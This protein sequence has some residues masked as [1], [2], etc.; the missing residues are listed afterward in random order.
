MRTH[1]TKK[2]QTTFW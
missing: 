1:F 2:T